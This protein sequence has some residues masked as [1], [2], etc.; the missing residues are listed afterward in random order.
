MSHCY[1]L[2]FLRRSFRWMATLE[3]QSV[4]LKVLVQYLKGVYERAMIIYHLRWWPELNWLGY[5][6]TALLKVG[7]QL[8][9]ITVQFTFRILPPILITHA[10]IGMEVFNE[11]LSLSNCIQLKLFIRL[12]TAMEAWWKKFWAGCK[13]SLRHLPD[14]AYVPVAYF[15]SN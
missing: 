11:A 9:S 4:V 5:R 6:N 10:N 2:M 1:P 8:R 12:G 14:F 3:L 13:K 7:H 15:S